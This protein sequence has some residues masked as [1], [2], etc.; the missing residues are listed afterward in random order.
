MSGAEPAKHSE[1]VQ[2]TVQDTGQTS[3]Q[4]LARLEHEA[5]GGDAQ[6]Q[7]QLGR[8]RLMAGDAGAAKALLEQACAQGSLEAQ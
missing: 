7:T 6:A 3:A 1:T 5:A 4:E 2:D 8:I